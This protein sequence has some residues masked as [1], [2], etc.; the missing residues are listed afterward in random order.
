MK[1][2]KADIQ[3]RHMILAD[4]CIKSDRKTGGKYDDGT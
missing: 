2:G 1:A 4:H 3:K